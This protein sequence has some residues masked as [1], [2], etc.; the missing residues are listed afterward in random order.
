MIRL[1][2]GNTFQEI[3]MNTF[4]RS[5]NEPDNL[6][7]LTSD[8]VFKEVLGQEESKPILMVFLNDMLDLHITSPDQL[9]LLNPELNPEYTDD[10]LSILDIRV[11]LTDRTSIDVE[12]QVIDQHN[13]EPRALY[14]VCRLCADQLQRGDDYT[15]L[16]PSIGFNLLCFNLYNDEDYFRSFV[17]KDKKTNTEYPN[18]LE[19]SFL[20][21]F[22]GLSHLSNLSKAERSGQSSVLSARDQWILFLTAKDK[23]VQ[24]EL[25]ENN[26][27]LQ[28]AY[29]RLVTVSSDEKLRVLQLNREKALRDWNSSIHSAEE[30]GRKL[31]EAHGQKLGEA[32]INKLVQCLLADNRLDELSQAVSNSDIQ[33]KLLAE[34]HI[35][36]S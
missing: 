15:L 16:R 26:T 33:Q 20:E 30:R 22:K 25:A 31:G 3:F 35:S 32:R 10:K 6:L 8:I 4:S 24:Q 11:Q 36:E 17:L 19:L 2:A 13:I 27:T 12:I 9:I 28:A 34:Y 18:Y 5:T 14:Y 1:E 29:N 7:P 23:E 21:L